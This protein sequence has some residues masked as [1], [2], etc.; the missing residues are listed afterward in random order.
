[1]IYNLPNTKKTQLPSF[2]KLM[3]HSLFAIT[4]LLACMFCSGTTGYGQEEINPIK[5]QTIMHPD[6]SRTDTMKDLDART[7]D[8]KIYNKK[9][10]LIQHS[11]FTLDDQERE[12]EGT[13]YDANE[14]VIGYVS[15]KYD[16]LGQ[17]KERSEKDANGKLFRR[18]VYRRDPSGKIIGIDAFD[19]NGL[20]I[21]SQ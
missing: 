10:K 1:M 16:V 18:L 15:N 3:K 19:G 2:L 5:V 9:G 17:L 13:I 6:G 12:I 21:K 11:V 14:K 7:T 4:L 20:P 8:V